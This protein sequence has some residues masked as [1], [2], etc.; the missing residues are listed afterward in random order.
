M[1]KHPEINVQLTGEDGNAHGIIG[2]VRR[3]L[4]AGGVRQSEVD[5]FVAEAVA[6]DYDNL[7]R[8][9][10]EWVNVS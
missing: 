9:C 6:S 1:T 5:R 4:I 3:A 10:M 8:V 2:R 7:L